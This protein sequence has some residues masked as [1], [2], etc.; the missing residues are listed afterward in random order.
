MEHQNPEEKNDSLPLFGGGSAAEPDNGGTIHVSGAAIPASLPIPP[1]KAVPQAAPAA[2]AVDDPE[3]DEAYLRSLPQVDES[4][5]VVAGKTEKNASASSRRI[6][7]AGVPVSSFGPYL[8]EVRVRN[9]VSIAEIAD[10]TKIRSTYIEA[11]EAE[12]FES[13]PPTVYVLAYVKKLCA[14]FQLPDN[15]V[16]E[17]TA[18]IQHHL[19]YEAPDDPTKTV[20]DIELSQ[21]N[22]I[23]FKRI[24]ILGGI[25]VFLVV[26]LVS[27]A[28]FLLFP[29]ERAVPVG[30]PDAPAIGSGVSGGGA[31]SSIN[32]N[33]LINLQKTPELEINELEQNPTR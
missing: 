13:L 2:P 30:G 3:E 14:Y 19:Q 20:V 23:L 15:V 11:V 18:E 27:L 29:A 8:R 25:G 24:L 32:E 26:L 21:E 33:T 10:A 9:K 6:N 16:E 28:V 22:P 1:T 31:E 12:D 7:I 17:L 5:E 4:T